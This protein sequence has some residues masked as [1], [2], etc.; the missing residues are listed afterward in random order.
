M[1]NNIKH[2]EK[3]KKKKKGEREVS[4]PRT[5]LEMKIIQNTTKAVLK[6][7]GLSD[8]DSIEQATPLNRQFNLFSTHFPV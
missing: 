7:T 8:L 1:E 2:K 3:L 4:I 5:T 6:T